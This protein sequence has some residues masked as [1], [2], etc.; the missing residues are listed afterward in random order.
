MKIITISNVEKFAKTLRKPSS[1][2]SKKTVE[3]IILD[4]KKR[5]DSAIRKYEKKFGT[6]ISSLRVSKR[7]IKD[8]YSQ[9]TKTEVEAIKLSKNRLAKNETK[10]RNQ[11]KDF[12]MDNDGIKI[13]RSFTPIN[14]VG[15][16]VP[17]GLARYPSS[18][19]MS[20]VPAKIAGVQEIIVV[21][22]P[23]K[24]GQIDSLTLVA[25]DICGATQI[26]K[27]GG[28]QAIG[29]LAFGTKTIPKV[30][31]IVGPGGVF[32]SEAKFFV[33]NTTAID[34][35]AGPTELT[36]LADEKSN[37]EYVAL[38]LI[39]QA[40]HS[41]DTFCCLITTSRFLA[42]KVR[43]SV[44]NKLKTIKRKKI[45]QSS[46]EKSGLITIC[47][48]ESDM[49]KLANELAPEHLEIMTKNSKKISQKIKTAGLILLGKNTPSSVSDYLL[50]SNHILPTSRFGRIRGSLSVLD[51][52][53]LNTEVESN[54]RTLQKISKYLKAYTAAE[55]LPNHYE[56]LKGRTK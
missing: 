7:E 26:F 4:V 35:I 24:Q 18:A 25:A 30:D 13:K 43:E 6:N 49:I 44:N 5:G 39:S 51:F 2:A 11:L 36:I 28:A 15:C 3:T 54:E 37:P 19:V 48:N 14:S 42:N 22:P 10:L 50:G 40:E 16:Y 47:K 33:S 34:M 46:L 41:K 31:K 12:T 20:I 1:Q 27:T 17:G 9:V 53:K 38:D 29:A 52:V 45:V 21:S 56:A 55:D 32:V 8:A 23:N